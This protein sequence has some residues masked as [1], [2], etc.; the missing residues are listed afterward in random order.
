MACGLRYSKVMLEARRVL[1][2]LVVLEG[3]FLAPAAHG[4]A[5]PLPPGPPDGALSS[6]LGAVPPPPPPLMVPQPLVAP[7]APLPPL[8]VQSRFRTGRVLYGIGTAVGLLGSGLTLGSIVVTSVYGIG[9]GNGQIGPALAYAGSGASGVAVIFSATGL[10]LQHSALGLVAQD[11]GR[12]L[13]G[14]GTLFG[15]LGLLGVGTSYYFSLASPVDNS[16]VV[17]FG[18]SIA[19]TVLLSVGGILYFADSQRLAKVYR[20]LTTF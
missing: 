20:R 2:I 13:Y 8:E 16:S 1:P 17:A 7:S 5:P 15:V 19:A 6:D 4:Q 12:G 3:M 9:E 14:I 11:P 10:G 18:T